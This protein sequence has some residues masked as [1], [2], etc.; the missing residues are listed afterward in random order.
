M[1]Y[2]ITIV[3]NNAEDTENAVLLK[4]TLDAKDFTAVVYFMKLQIPGLEI[5][6]PGDYEHE[7]YGVLIEDTS[8]KSKPK[9]IPPAPP[10]PPLIVPPVVVSD[11]VV[12]EMVFDAETIEDLE[13]LDT[14]VASEE[15][16]TDAPIIGEQGITPISTRKRRIT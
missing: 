9:P 1:P 12:E 4:E 10:V 3:D 14:E 5:K 13:E 2:K 11:D 15:S 6:E 7:G 16:L 8:A